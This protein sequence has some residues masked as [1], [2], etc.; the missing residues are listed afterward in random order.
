MFI[1][2]RKISWLINLHLFLVRNALEGQLDCPF[3]Q[4][5][6]IISCE[7]YIFDIVV[8]N[9]ANDITSILHRHLQACSL[10]FCCKIAHLLGLMILILT[11]CTRNQFYIKRRENKLN[12]LSI[13]GNFYF[14]KISHL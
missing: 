11:P 8:L 4:S 14:V 13:K 6:I 3:R 9:H 5:R 2:R 12:S 10:P 1:K 7:K